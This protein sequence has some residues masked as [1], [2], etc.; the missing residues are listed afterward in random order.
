MRKDQEKH[1]EKRATD[2]DYKALLVEGLEEFA[3]SLEA[4]EDI[5]ERFSCHKVVLD[6]QHTSYDKDLVKQTRKML[7]A[8]Q[9]IFARFLGVWV[10]AIS[11][12]E[13]GL[14]E[15][16]QMACRF[17]DEICQ[18]PEHWRERLRQSVRPKTV[19]A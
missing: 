13:Q 19:K 16:N 14:K 11:S 8:S 18:D 4:G 9:A 17:M 6:L 5:T 12:W 10:S 3:G 15:P 1:L 2:H 7:G